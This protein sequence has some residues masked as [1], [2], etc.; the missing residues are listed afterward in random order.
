MEIPW[1]LF[2][3]LLFVMVLIALL[4][5]GVS[6]ALM[7]ARVSVGLTDAELRAKIDLEYQQAMAERREY[8]NILS[9]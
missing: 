8:K 4:I 1:V 5:Q 2:L 3:Q 7:R 6:V 9:K